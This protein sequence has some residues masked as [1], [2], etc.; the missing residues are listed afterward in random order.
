M[1]EESTQNRQPQRPNKV[2]PIVPPFIWPEA[3]WH[4]KAG[5]Y[6][7]HPPFDDFLADADLING[8]IVG[9]RDGT[10][11]WVHTLMQKDGARRLVLVLIVYPACPTRE[12]H[13]H[14]LLHL[15]FQ[16]AGA[17]KDLDLLLLPFDR[18]YGRD[19]ERMVLPPTVLQ[20]Y[21]SKSGKTLL[22][23]GSVGD[24]GRDKVEFGSFNMV[25][26]P[27]DG[28]RDE[29]RKWFQFIVSSAV[30]LTPETVQIPHLIP[31]EGDPE[32][33]ERWAEFVNSCS[34][35]GLEGSARPTVDI[36]TG[37]VTKEADGSQ[38]QPWDSGK[39][40]LDHLAQVLQRVY[41]EGWLV[42]IDEATRIKPLGIPVKAALMGER[43]E[44]MVGALKHKQSFS[45]KIL[46]DDVDKAIE[47]SRKVTDLMELLTYPLSQGN[48]FLPG[49]AKVLLNKELDSRNTRGHEALQGA[50]G[51]RDIAAE[52]C[53]EI[54]E[55]LI[56][57]GSSEILESLQ[58]VWLASNRTPE[59]AK[60][61]IEEKKLKPDNETLKQTLQLAIS[62]HCIMQFIRRRTEGICKDLN[63]MYRRFGKGDVVPQEKLN[64]VLLDIKERLMNAL[65]N[66]ITPRAVLNR[67]TAPDLTA[68]APDENWNQPLL[69]LTRSARVLRESLT[70]SYFQRRFTGLTFSADE[71]RRA[72]NV[73]EDT[74]VTRPDPHRAKNELQ[75]IDDILKKHLS[76][77]EKCLEL[78]HL[79]KDHFDESNQP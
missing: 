4:T 58:N 65:N 59:A 22:S 27:D 52:A 9:A 24:C 36:V 62:K 31:A 71:F 57:S 17:G 28:L 6:K 50:L 26:Q 48:R 41:S 47:K 3:R 8:V 33:Q 39:T 42:T 2:L 21:E 29:W 1:I 54:V 70:D 51:A 38:V 34:G 53:K 14:K 19:F 46:D 49:D 43:S 63:E 10:A 44:S 45:L 16:I 13:L 20:A 76:A 61:I 75:Q 12:E 30:P 64:T 69:L 7:F 15:K 72:C 66:R 77:K 56:K 68:T 79:T 55:A 11:E 37:E 74:I 78:W 73:F 32:A 18:V 23:V 67:I 25:F 60:K 35:F 5:I 40:K